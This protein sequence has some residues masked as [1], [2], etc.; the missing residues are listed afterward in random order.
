VLQKECDISPDET[1]GEVY[2]N[3]LY[4]MGVKAM[5][6]A[7]ELYEGFDPL[8]HPAEMKQFTSG[9]DQAWVSHKARADEAYWD[10]RDGVL[11]AA[12]GK[13]RGVEDELPPGARIVFFPGPRIPTMPDIRNRFP[14]IDQHLPQ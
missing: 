4:P 8:R 10:E 13:G 6:E 7:A 11:G 3:K 2:F 12:R 14:W 5:L 9:T 1:I